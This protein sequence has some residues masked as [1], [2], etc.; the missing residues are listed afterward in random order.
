MKRKKSTEKNTSS[1]TSTT[2]L[3]TILSDTGA[4]ISNLGSQFNIVMMIEMN[5]DVFKKILSFLSI[6]DL[7]LQRLVR[8]NFKQAADFVFEFFHLLNI[9]N[10]FSFKDNN[11]LP[12]Q[13]VIEFRSECEQITKLYTEKLIQTMGVEKIA[14]FPKKEADLIKDAMGRNELTIHI[15]AKVN[16]P[17]KTELL[18]QKI[19]IF[20]IANQYENKE[21]HILKKLCTFE[22]A[23]KIL[24]H[25]L[26]AAQYDYLGRLVNNQ[27]CGKIVD[28]VETEPK[29]TNNNQPLVQLCDENGK[30]L[31]FSARKT[32]LKL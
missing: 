10:M 2:T 16:M 4:M 7:N 30:I 23:G 5:D 12:N 22:H 26:C 14:C 13:K 27:P 6:Y 31:D 8:K 21:L 11:A 28:G 24:P 18:S 20:K 3:S 29:V 15:Y 25:F 1:S 32:G 19:N 9:P 17:E